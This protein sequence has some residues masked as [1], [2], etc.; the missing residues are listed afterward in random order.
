MKLNIR[1]IG[2]DDAPFSFDH[3]KVLVV[4]NL[5]RA[6]NYLE[7]ILST[8]VSVDGRD[9]TT[10]IADMITESRFAEQAKVI[11]TDGGA[12]G[13]FNVIDLEELFRKTNTPVISVSRDEPDFKNIKGA[14]KGHF[15][16]WKTRFDIFKNGEIYEVETKHLPIYIQP[17]GLDLNEAKRLLKLFTVRGRLPEPIRISHI[18]A[19]GIVRGESRGKP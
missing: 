9:A 3:E 7:G 11:F 16:D 19:S 5:T 12:V 8:Y 1:A 14:L 10:K 17:E 15:E 13:G 6:P 18:V 4:G 2:I